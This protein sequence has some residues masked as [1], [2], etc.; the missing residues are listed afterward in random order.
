VYAAG[1]RILFKLLKK[2]PPIKR[3][4]ENEI[5][6]ARTTLNNDVA[7]LY[8]GKNGKCIFITKLPKKGYSSVT[9]LEMV[10]QYLKLGKKNCCL[11]K[12]LFLKQ[13]S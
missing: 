12:F 7:E 1:K 9:V 5:Q 4:V 13:F 10:A 11:F 2:L 3:H 8:K 6:K